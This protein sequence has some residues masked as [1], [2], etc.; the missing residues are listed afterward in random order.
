MDPQV[1]QQLHQHVLLRQAALEFP[2][3]SVYFEENLDI[4][5]SHGCQQPDVVNKQFE[6]RDVPVRGQR[7]SRF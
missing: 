7:D 5:V 6:G 1:G 3:Y 2:L 4:D